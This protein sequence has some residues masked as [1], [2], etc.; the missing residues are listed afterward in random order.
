VPLNEAIAA[1][2][3]PGEEARAARFHREE[4][5]DRYLRSHAALRIILGRLTSA[6]LEFAVTESGKPYLPAA[7]ELKFNLSHSGGTALVGAALEVEI[8]VDVERVRPL[9]DF[10]RMA[11]RFFPPSQAAE[12]ADEADFFRRWTRIEAAA[13]ARGV[14]I[15][16]IGME[17]TGEWTIVDLDAGPGYSAA[18]ALP[19]AGIRVLT[20]DFRGDA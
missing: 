7:P 16:G 1:P 2:P 11:Q 19:R 14:G 15:Y 6:R 17:L 4:D 9:S 10:A 3:T 5:R 20:H 18:A 13:K 12:V 8:G